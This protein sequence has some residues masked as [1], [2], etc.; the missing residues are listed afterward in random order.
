LKDLPKA[1]V[2]SN[3]LK[4]LLLLQNSSSV[5]VSAKNAV[6]VFLSLAPEFVPT[7]ATDEFDSGE[8]IFNQFFIF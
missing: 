4:E 2:V 3:A 7:N 1:A 8:F 6:A 5:A